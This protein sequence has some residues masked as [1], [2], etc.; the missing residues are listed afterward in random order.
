MLF[1]RI[2]ITLKK[3]E[4]WKKKKF[5][6]ISNSK[7][8]K[9][10]SK[11]LNIKNINKVGILN[12]ILRRKIT[13][14][15]LKIHKKNDSCKSGLILI[16]RHLYSYRRCWT[17]LRLYLFVFVF[18][19]S[20]FPLLF[21]PFSLRSSFSSTS[22]R[23]FQDCICFLEIARWSPHKRNGMTIA[24]VVLLLVAKPAAGPLFGY[25]PISGR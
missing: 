25:G 16:V 18:F 9:N 8:F 11:R 19:F 10:L 23:A 5:L 24:M 4:Y 21:S 14:F 13:P 6:S 1:V 17:R 7:V 12:S 2:I 22:C 3:I 15:T 20:I